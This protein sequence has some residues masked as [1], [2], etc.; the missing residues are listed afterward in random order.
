VELSAEGWRAF[1]SW[2]ESPEMMTTGLGRSISAS[3]ADAVE[4]SV[5]VVTELAA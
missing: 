3:D 4:S 1:G 5:I 2:V